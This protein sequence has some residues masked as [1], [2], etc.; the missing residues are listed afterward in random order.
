MVRV[1]SALVAF[2][3]FCAV[4]LAPAESPDGAYQPERPDQP[5]MPGAGQLRGGPRGVALAPPGSVQVN[6]DGNGL[7]IVGDAANE[8][9]ITIDPTNPL[10]MA[11]GWRQ[12]DNIASNFRQA[13][14]AFTT[15]GGLTWT[16][17]GVLEP[18]VFRSDPVLCADNAGTFFYNSLQ[19][20]FCMD[21]W[22]STNGG[23]T[24]PNLVPAFG[25]DKQWM[26]VDR[27]GGIGEG[28]LYS[29]WQSAAVCSGSSS[30]LFTRSTDHGL[31]WMSPIA[32]PNNLRF[33][34]IHVASNGDVFVTGTSNSNASNAVVVRSSNAENSAVTPT[35]DF[36][37]VSPILGGSQ[38]L[39]TGPNPAGLLGQVQIVTRPGTPS[40]VYLLCSVNPA[41]AD[42]LDVRF[43]RSIDGGQTWS[44]SIK[45]NDDTSTTAYQWFGTISVAPNGRIDVVWNDTKDDPANLLSR[46]YYSFSVDEGVTWSASRALTPQWNSQ[47]GFP[48]QNKIGDY[49]QMISYNDAAHLAYAA[50]FN[51][52]QDVYYMRIT[53]LPVCGTCAADLTGDSSTDGADIAA[54]MS[55]VLRFPVTASSCGCADMNG[56]QIIDLN[57]IAPFVDRL[58]M[59]G[60]P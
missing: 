32:F 49:Y 23:A 27:T 1:P 55:C 56:D 50:T 12:F 22:R 11:I 25:G 29:H 45:V 35:W 57:D 3:F 17:P 7:N 20:T 52:E 10:R 19:G 37:V 48:S 4:G 33:G 40:H 38:T 34:T 30:N 46:T 16:F 60:C 15:D 24:W 43:A 42:P 58:L 41:G 59:G 44:A 54:F 6:V 39:S 5:Y 2:I 28:N 51:G 26:D 36:S 47:L 13:G 9:S 18:G 31:T 8:P 14:Y 53:P 21:V